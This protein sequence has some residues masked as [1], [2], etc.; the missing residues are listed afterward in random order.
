MAVFATLLFSYLQVDAPNERNSQ[1]YATLEVAKE[2]DRLYYNSCVETEK[3]L[4]LPTD[5]EL[6]RLE[7]NVARTPLVSSHITYSH[8]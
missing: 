1:E 3:T 4:Q 6:M 2:R 5:W 8:A 7:E